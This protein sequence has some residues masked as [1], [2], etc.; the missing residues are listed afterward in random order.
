[1]AW[2]WGLSHTRKGG[3]MAGII[4]SE[5]YFCKYWERR[6]FLSFHLFGSMNFLAIVAKLGCMDRLGCSC[7]YSSVFFMFINGTAARAKLPPSQ[8]GKSKGCVVA[9]AQRPQRSVRC[10]AQNF[11]ASTGTE[12]QFYS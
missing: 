12:I 2:G 5:P 9:V 4:Y 10:A 1:V 11:T 8:Q 6:E 7:L 3:P